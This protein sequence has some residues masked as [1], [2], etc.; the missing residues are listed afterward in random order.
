MLLKSETICLTPEIAQRLL[1]TV[2]TNRSIS[3]ST[4]ECYASDM[5]EGRWY[6]NGVPITLDSEGTL[7]DG[8]HRC[9]AVIKADVII[10]CVLH[11]ISGNSARGFDLNRVRS[12]ADTVRLEGIENGAFRSNTMIGAINLSIV[13]NKPYSSTFWKPSKFEQI[14]K[15]MKHKESIDFV[16]ST[17]SSGGSGIR[18]SGVY[19]AILCA[20]ENGYDK[21]KLMKFTEVLKS[22]LMENRDEESIIRLREFLI[23]NTLKNQKRSKEICYT[24]MNVLYNYDKGHILTKI[25]VSTEPKYPII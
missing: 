25:Y 12:T 7:I 5:R 6:D 2:K 24:T 11:T 16:Y 13:L 8:Q 17:M 3:R 14:D 15:M 4:V 9:A 10:P 20:Y 19:L 23:R 22:G 21:Q 1:D 18:K